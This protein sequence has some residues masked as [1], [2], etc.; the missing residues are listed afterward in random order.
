MTALTTAQ[1]YV[2]IQANVIYPSLP[3]S[4]I[5]KD[6][7]D[8]T[9]R[10]EPKAPE[11]EDSSLFVDTDDFGLIKSKTDDALTDDDDEKQTSP[12]NKN[13]RVNYDE[14]N[15]VIDKSTLNS[16]DARGSKKIR[17]DL[18]QEL[19]GFN[20]YTSEIIP[21]A[22]LVTELSRDAKSKLRKGFNN[23]CKLEIINRSLKLPLGKQIRWQAMHRFGYL[24]YESVTST[25]EQFRDQAN[26]KYLQPIFQ[27]LLDLMRDELHKA[28]LFG[29]AVTTE[30]ARNTIDFLIEF[31][32]AMPALLQFW[33][34]VFLFHTSVDHELIYKFEKQVKIPDSKD[35]ETVTTEVTVYHLKC[36]LLKIFFHLAER[37][38]RK[39]FVRMDQLWWGKQYGVFEQRLQFLRQFDAIVGSD[40]KPVLAADPTKDL[41]AKTDRLKM[42][43]DTITRDVA[44]VDELETKL[45]KHAR[46]PIIQSTQLDVSR[47]LVGLSRKL[48]AISNLSSSRSTAFMQQ[49]STDTISNIDRMI[50]LNEQASV[51]EEFLTKKD[52]VDLKSMKSELKKLASK[53]KFIKNDTVTLWS[54]INK[55]NVLVQN[56]AVETLAL[57]ELKLQ[58][59]KIKLNALTENQNIQNEDNF[60]DLLDVCGIWGLCEMLLQAPVLDWTSVQSPLSLIHE[61]SRDPGLIVNLNFGRFVDDYGSLPVTQINIDFDA[62][63][64]LSIPT[65]SKLYETQDHPLLQ[66]N[67]SRHWHIACRALKESF[68]SRCRAHIPINDALSSNRRDYNSSH[69]SADSLH[70]TSEVYMTLFSPRQDNDTHPVWNR[71]K[72]FRET[73]QRWRF[74]QTNL[75][76]LQDWEKS[77]PDVQTFVDSFDLVDSVTWGITSANDLRNKSVSQAACLS[78]IHLSHKVPLLQAF[79]WS[80]SVTKNSLQDRRAKNQAYGSIKKP[81]TPVYIEFDEIES[82]SYAEFNVR[83]VSFGNQSNRLQKAR[84]Q[85]QEKYAAWL[86]QYL[87]PRQ[88]TTKN[89]NYEPQMFFKLEANNNKLTSS[90]FDHILANANIKSSVDKVYSYLKAYA[91]QRNPATFVSATHKKPVKTLGSLLIL[92]L[93][94]VADNAS[95]EQDADRPAKQSS[96]DSY[97]MTA[98]S[99]D[100]QDNSQTASDLVRLRDNLLA[101]YCLKPVGTTVYET[102]DH[103]QTWSFYL[104]MVCCDLIR[105]DAQLVTDVSDDQHTIFTPQ[106]CELIKNY[107]HYYKIDC[108]EAYS[109]VCQLV[110]QAWSLKER[111]QLYRKKQEQETEIQKSIND[112]I[113]SSNASYREMMQTWG[114]DIVDRWSLLLSFEFTGRADETQDG[115]K[116]VTTSSVAEALFDENL[117]QSSYTPEHNEEVGER[118]VQN[119]VQVVLEM[120]RIAVE[121]FVLQFQPANAQPG[122][123]RNPVDVNYERDVLNN[124]LNTKLLNGVLLG[125]VVLHQYNDCLLDLVDMLDRY[126]STPTWSNADSL[127][128]VYKDLMVRRSRYA[129]LLH[130]LQSIDDEFHV[131]YTQQ[132][133]PQS[134]VTDRS[135]KFPASY[136]GAH[137]LEFSDQWGFWDTAVFHYCTFHVD[138]DLTRNTAILDRDAAYQ[139]I[140]DAHQAALKQRQARLRNTGIARI[141]KVLY[142]EQIKVIQDLV[143]ERKELARRMQTYDPAYYKSILPSLVGIKPAELRAK[144]TEFYERNQGRTPPLPQQYQIEEY[145]SNLLDSLVPMIPEIE[146]LDEIADPDANLDLALLRLQ[147]DALMRTTYTSPT[148]LTSPTDADREEMQSA[149]D[150]RTKGADIYRNLVAGSVEISVTDMSLAEYESQFLT[151]IERYNSILS[152]VPKWYKLL[153]Q[154]QS[155]MPAGVLRFPSEYPLAFM[156]E[157]GSLNESIILGIE[158]NQIDDDDEKASE[159]INDDDEKDPGFNLDTFRRKVKPTRQTALVTENA[160]LFS[161]L[162]DLRAAASSLQVRF[163]QQLIDF[164]ASHAH[165]FTDVTKQAL[166][167]LLKAMTGPVIPSAAVIKERLDKY[168]FKNEKN[169]NAE[170]IIKTYIQL[171]GLVDLEPKND[172]HSMKLPVGNEV[173]NVVLDEPNKIN[174]IVVDDENEDFENQN[175]EDVNDPNFNPGDAKNVAIS[176]LDDEENEDF[177]QQEVAKLKVKRERKTRV[178]HEPQNSQADQQTTEAGNTIARSL[179]ETFQDSSSDSEEGDADVTFVDDVED[180]F[181]DRMDAETSSNEED[182]DNDSVFKAFE[183]DEDDE[184]D[185]SGDDDS[186]FDYE[187]VQKAKDDK[188]FRARQR[189]AKAASAASLQR[190]REER[191]D[192]VQ[193]LGTNED[194]VQPRYETQATKQEAQARQEDTTP[195]ADEAQKSNE[196][197]KKI[198]QQSIQNMLDKLGD[199]E[200]RGA[201]AGQ[202]NSFRSSLTIMQSL[203]L[204]PVQLQVMLQ[205]TAVGIRNLMAANPPARA[206]I[207]DSSNSNS[208]QLPPST[209]RSRRSSSSGSSGS[210]RD[211]TTRSPPKDPRNDKSAR[212]GARFDLPSSMLFTDT[213]ETLKYLNKLKSKPRQVSLAASKWIEGE[214]LPGC[215]KRTEKAYLNAGPETR[216]WMLKDILNRLFNMK[217]DQETFVYSAAVLAASLINKKYSGYLE[218]HYELIRNY[219][220]IFHPVIGNGDITNGKRVQLMYDKCVEYQTPSRLP[221]FFVNR[222]TN[223]WLHVAPHLIDTEYQVDYHLTNGSYAKFLTDSMR[224]IE[225]LK[226]LQMSFM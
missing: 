12:T 146:L 103:L 214:L 84:F 82:R 161:Q 199:L 49:A 221:A 158:Q 156:I 86:Q 200:Q 65:L 110:F 40:G 133:G 225:V 111:A 147:A 85:T 192:E 126:F 186:S 78:S 137:F 202:I 120:T 112:I 58:L 97:V 66:L 201:D 108:E 167:K 107:H 140:F 18:L 79:L 38:D 175:D 123:E 118:Q 1:K 222:V 71:Y 19:Q 17:T 25:I 67:L 124:D 223:F 91:L 144:Y 81:I 174:Y 173:F 99:F 115:A 50:E 45:I 60:D 109:T 157:G 31:L 212:T 75:S 105:R 129:E 164:D 5:I 64:P 178:K 89:S 80:L 187:A 134:T 168:K 210:K 194:Y 24:N 165:F 215:L 16:F 166:R 72:E 114:H 220:D 190:L 181:D 3:L 57:V 150:K 224:N 219:D 135:K 83:D 14:A 132:N 70:L 101:E 10:L 44:D 207:A 205:P 176:I 6:V 131:V 152:R 179:L 151:S 51:D 182:D 148:Y 136:P 177:G 28:R 196:D 159:Q 185:D 128:T 11:V 34:Y 46:L 48:A 171:F 193:L 74:S 52:T 9:K 198:N 13:E 100:E 37:F 197:Q 117:M 189:K 218:D 87:K 141:L 180:L 76:E 33:S 43:N 56:Q 68:E 15:D 203:Q 209:H 188:D 22:A 139:T 121:S 27:E 127:E 30:Q 96:Q 160:F 153:D 62:S 106:Q 93:G 104:L 77:Y 145:A 29:L 163:Q 53:N 35:Y 191:D 98:V 195:A 59:N 63:D 55:I 32:S 8:V 90:K 226:S 95:F 216:V 217:S 119:R 73:G 54:L 42:L 113:Q 149:A 23:I 122:Q 143:P 47:L 183:E 184:D 206:I 88:L 125:K 142:R 211:R 21:P 162:R 170:N 208:L 20:V 138:D 213:L 130:N 26:Q 61:F 69:S 92:E 169:A 41:I 4:K 204:D 116:P 154:L 36:M 102:H 172:T 94:K 155:S 39:Y 7:D 2:K